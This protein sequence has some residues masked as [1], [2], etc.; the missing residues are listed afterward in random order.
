MQDHF[1]LLNIF[2]L[3]MKGGVLR[4]SRFLKQIKFA[5]VTDGLRNAKAG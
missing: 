1:K 3:F 5:N 2:T 4:N